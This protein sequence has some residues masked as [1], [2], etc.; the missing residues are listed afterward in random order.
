MWAGS[1]GRPFG[2]LLEPKSWLYRPKN[3]VFAFNAASILIPNWL[4]VV[5]AGSVSR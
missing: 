5:R 3:V 4:P 2:T 1:L